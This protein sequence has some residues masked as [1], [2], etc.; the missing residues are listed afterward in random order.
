MKN[1]RKN[2]EY[3][4]RTEYMGLRRTTVS[5]Y[6]VPTFLRDTNLAAYMLN[7]NDIVSATY[8]GMRGKW[9]FD[10]MLDVKTFYSIPKWLDVEGLRLPVIVSGRKPACWRCGEIGHLS[11][12]C[13]GKKTP[14]KYDLNP[15]TLS[16]V[17]VN[18]KKEAPGV[19]PTVRATAPESTGKQS[20]APPLSSTA[21]TEESRAE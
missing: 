15:V 6:E 3:F 9:W 16:P 13:L 10:I 1:F 2:K 19:S 17:V 4:F 8:D 20:P 12:V 7:F 5:V 21:T 14:K 11:A 18:E